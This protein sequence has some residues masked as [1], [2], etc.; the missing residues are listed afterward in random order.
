M[1]DN[2][3]PPIILH[4]VGKSSLIYTDGTM[5]T[6]DKSKN[7]KFEVSAQTGKQEGGDGLFPLLKFLTSK[8]GTLTIED[9]QF[10]LDQAKFITGGAIV[11]GAEVNKEE[12]VVPSAGSATLSVTKGI[13]T[14]TVVVINE[15]TGEPLV[16]TSGDTVSA[17]QF[18][19]T[20]AGVLTVDS[21]LTDK[22]TVNYM[23]KAED[24]VNLAVLNSSVAKP[25][26]LRHTIVTDEM[27]DGKRY[28]LTFRAFKVR[29][30]G[31]FSYNAQRGEAYS[32]SM[33]FE[34][35]ESGREDKKVYTYSVVEYKE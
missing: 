13:E 23:Y 2:K 12:T 10:S 31:A 4:G 15:V 19:V 25:C 18:K 8:T 7:F 33:K 16:A 21:K 6:I 20:D 9:A 30:D 32:P 3:I 27:A 28:K 26:E 24:G 34:L 14:D 17:G 1:A 29:S 11:K 5:L 22:L 35:E